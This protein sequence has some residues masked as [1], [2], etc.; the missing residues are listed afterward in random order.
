MLCP[1][2]PIWMI[3]AERLR[4]ETK[5]NCV[6]SIYIHCMDMIQLGYIS[7]CRCC[8]ASSFSPLSRDPTQSAT[9]GWTNQP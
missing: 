2:R 9:A 5:L 4:S 3:V 7:Y 1:G 8:S 6:S